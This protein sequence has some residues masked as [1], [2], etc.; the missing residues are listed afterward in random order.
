MIDLFGLARCALV[1]ALQV[2]LDVVEGPAVIVQ[3]LVEEGTELG[4]PDRAASTEM[5]IVEA[6]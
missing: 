1:S 4:P 3:G 6:A 5:V 2:R